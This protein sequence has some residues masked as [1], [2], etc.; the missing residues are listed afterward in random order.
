MKTKDWTLLRQRQSIALPLVNLFVKTICRN[1]RIKSRTKAKVVATGLVALKMMAGVAFAQQNVW[2]GTSSNN[3]FF[4]LNWSLS[5]V[6]TASDSALINTSFFAPTVVDEPGA[7]A[8]Q[9]TVSNNP[10]GSLAPGSLTIESPGVL[11]VGA[12]GVLGAAASPSGLL[13]PAPTR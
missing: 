2:F 3:W 6:P 11:N 8:A 4:P 7:V 9:L 1:C 10:P 12:L 5:R 13:I